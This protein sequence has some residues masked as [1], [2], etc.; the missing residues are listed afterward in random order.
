MFLT[1]PWTLFSMLKLNNELL[2]AEKNISY[3]KEMTSSERYT[4][5]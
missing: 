5:V 2:E 3:E 1:F 4:I